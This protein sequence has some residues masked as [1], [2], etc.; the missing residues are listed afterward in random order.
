MNTRRSSKQNQT[1][2]TIN[3][4]HTLNIL[5]IK[6]QRKQILKAALID[7]FW[8]VW[9]LKKSASAN[10]VGKKMLARISF[11]TQSQNLCGVWC[12]AGCMRPVCSKQFPA[13]AGNQK[14]QICGTLTHNKEQK[15]FFL[16]PPKKTQKTAPNISVLKCLGLW[17]HKNIRLLL[18]YTERVAMFHFPLGWG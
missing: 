8:Q 16:T 10:D 14:Q 9:A 17:V 3:L 1:E 15:V 6:N 4:I 13:I 2:E 12:L 7:L 11:T 18:F 5:T